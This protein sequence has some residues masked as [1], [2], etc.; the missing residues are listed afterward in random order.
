MK[1]FFLFIFCLKGSAI[2]FAQEFTPPDSAAIVKNHV[3]SVKIYYTGTGS[4]NLL[5]QEYRYDK[6]GQRVYSRDGSASYYYAFTYTEKR[7]LATSVQRSMTGAFIKAYNNEYD[8]NGKLWRMSTF[9]ERDTLH[10][11][12]NFIYDTAGNVV[13]ETHFINGKLI[14]SY[15]TKYDLN[16]KIIQ[17]IDSTPGKNAYE[18]VNSRTVRQTYY[19]ANGTMEQN[20]LLSYD[21][22]GRLSRT[23][24]TSGKYAGTYI[25]VYD[26]DLHYTLLKDGKEITHEE[27]WNWTPKFTWLLPKPKEEEYGLPY[28]DPVSSYEYVH[29]TSRDKKNNITLDIVNCKFVM[30]NCSTV[31]FDYEYEYW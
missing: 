31:Q 17:R 14:R 25:I 23:T 12:A 2:L 29:R 27:Y 21:S 16:H 26:K 15:Q 4:K 5:T 18:T 13:E 30:P 28:S 6:K 9:T 10:P 7:Q 8:D 20:W 3:K 19:D 24:C 22:T 11:E 1:K